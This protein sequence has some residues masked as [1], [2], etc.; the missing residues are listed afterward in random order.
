LKKDPHHKATTLKL[1]FNSAEIAAN[2]KFI[3]DQDFAHL[4]TIKRLSKQ[5]T[6]NI[7]A[8]QQHCFKHHYGRTIL[9]YI[10]EKRVEQ[11]KK[12]LVEG[13]LNLDYIAYEIGY[14]NRSGLTRPFKKHVGCRPGSGELM[15]RLNFTFSRNETSGP[16]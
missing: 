1:P 10:L 2:V 13:E 8:V 9:T 11:A 5:T 3:L 16:I 7:F 4:P 15:R 14:A 12:L 6:S